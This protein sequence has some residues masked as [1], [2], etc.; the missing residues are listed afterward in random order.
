M[1]LKFL[2]Y[3]E[4]KEKDAMIRHTA[5]VAKHY[6][7]FH[8]RRSHPAQPWRRPLM[9]RQPYSVAVPSIGGR[10]HPLVPE[11]REAW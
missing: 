11:G 1:F 5:P 8:S 7:R 9:V 2:S 3:E 6:C 4:I 10:L